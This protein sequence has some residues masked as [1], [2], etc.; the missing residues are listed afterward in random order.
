VPSYSKNLEAFKA[1]GVDRIIC[2]SVND[3]YCLNAW[4]K[5]LGDKANGIEFYAD[6]QGELTKYMVR[7]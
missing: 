1:K 3:P 6:V 2:V 5:A 7:S 4:K